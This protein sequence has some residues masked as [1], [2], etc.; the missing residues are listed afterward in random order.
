MCLQAELGTSDGKD[1][2]LVPLTPLYD[3]LSLVA[4]ACRVVTMP[5]Q[6]LDEQGLTPARGAAEG[7]GGEAAASAPAASNESSTRHAAQAPGQVQ[8]GLFRDP[9][10]SS[11]IGVHVHQPRGESP[12]V[13]Y[14]AA[15]CA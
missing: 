12:T 4:L 10:D 5:Q 15:S 6:R 13:C 14:P 9:W 1:C 7:E 8:I 11:T 3:L 2:L